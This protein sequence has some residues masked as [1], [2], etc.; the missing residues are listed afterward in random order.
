MVDT[1]RRR[2]RRRAGRC[3]V[4]VPVARK[5]PIQ[6]GDRTQLT[7]LFSV[8]LVLLIWVVLWR[9]GPPYVGGSGS[10][11]IKLVPF[12]SSDGAGASAPLEVVANVLLFVPFG[13]Y[14]GLLVPSWPRWRSVG[15]IAATSLA[16]ESAQYVLAVGVS[17]ITDVISNSTG[18]AIGLTLVA[19]ARLCF[20]ART[21]TV[22][23]RICSIATIVIVLASATFITSGVRYAPPGAPGHHRR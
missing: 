11:H 2:A 17:D 5:S 12:L 20:R 1:A 16:L 8:Y 7:A 4:A 18:G 9:L 13:L 21:T 15:V 6:A 23:K 10:R 22:M 3:G 19:A 14:L